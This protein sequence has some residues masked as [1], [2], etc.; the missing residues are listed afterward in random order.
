MK[1]SEAIELMMDTMMNVRGMDSTQ[2]KICKSTTRAQVLFAVSKLLQEYP[3]DYELSPLMKKR[4]KQ[5][6]QNRMKPI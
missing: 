4:V 3:A 5:V 6:C 1:Q 2:S